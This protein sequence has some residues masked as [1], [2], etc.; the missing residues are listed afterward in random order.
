MLKNTQ[1][2]GLTEVSRRLVVA[3]TMAASVL[4]L[5]NTPVAAQEPKVL[6]YSDHEPFG[7]MRT[8]FLKEVLFPAIEKE[9]NGRLKVEDHWNGELAVA[10]E[11]R[12]TV[13]A[14]KVTDLSTVVPEYSAK[15]MPLHQ[16]F[17]GFPMGPTGTKQIEFFKRVYDEVPEFSEEMAK[18]NLVTVYF[19]TGYPVAF[20]STAPINTLS[21]VAGGKWRTASFWHQDFLTNVGATPITMHWGP[22]VPAA[23][24]DGT[25]DGLMVNVDSGYMLKVHE[26]A[27]NVLASKDL[28]LGHVYLLAMNKATWDGLAQ[29]DK[30]AFHRAAESAYSTLGS[31]MDNSFNAQIKELQDA[32]ATVRV[33]DKAEA[34]QWVA[35]T[36]Y[37]DTQ[38]A[39]V[40]TQQSNGTKSVA[41]V[42]EKVR[43][44]MSEFSN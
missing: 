16:I 28:W 12:G 4:L 15:E 10:Y 38:D 35:T 29:E 11:A 19:G 31:V 17:K 13:S 42:V 6:V 25:I 3:T 37:Q 7:G 5:I 18:N 21:D 41:P 9:S 44:I 20:Y 23:L 2:L 33:L 14:G 43:S 36:K 8:R 26:V 34:A 39:W 32:G 22:E 24:K 30:D 40:K 27:P 1:K